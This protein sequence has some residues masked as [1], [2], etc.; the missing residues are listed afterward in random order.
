MTPLGRWS[1]LLAL[2]VVA[3][4]ASL[5]GNLPATG[6]KAEKRDLAGDA[7]S[8]LDSVLPTDVASELGDLLGGLEK[9]K[10][11]DLAAD[12]VSLLEEALPSQVSSILEGVLDGVEKKREEPQES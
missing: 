2:A 12:A 3:S 10:K 11:R 1:I 5:P 6:V 7:V 8:L 4:A 9:E